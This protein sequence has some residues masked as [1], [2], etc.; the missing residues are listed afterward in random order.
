[1]N[2]RINKQYRISESFPFP[3]TMAWLKIVVRCA[4]GCLE[5]SE[6]NPAP[7]VKNGKSDYICIRF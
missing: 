6:K 5:K 7:L 1:M 2:S 4:T 3:G